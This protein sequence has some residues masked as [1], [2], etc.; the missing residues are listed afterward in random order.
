MRQ[1]TQM[2]NE[3]WRAH[4]KDGAEHSDLDAN[5]LDL[6]R[7]SSRLS[8]AHS[9]LL[10]RAAAQEARRDMRRVHQRRFGDSR[11]P[12]LRRLGPAFP[13]AK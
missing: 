4:G 8:R 10:D 13:D 2:L 12:A 5:A 1:M 9:P 7:R 11:S 3:G 6:L